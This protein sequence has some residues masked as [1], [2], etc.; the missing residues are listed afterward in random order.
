MTRT[1]AKARRC[2]QAA[3]LSKAPL[4]SCAKPCHTPRSWQ[5]FSLEPLAVAAWP[6]VPVLALP[7]GGCHHLQLAWSPRPLPWGAEL[8]VSLGDAAVQSTLPWMAAE[9]LFWWVCF[10]S[11]PPPFSGATQPQLHPQPLGQLAALHP[12]ACD[13]HGPAPQIV[14][15]LE[16]IV[17]PRPSKHPQ[18]LPH[19]AFVTLPRTYSSQAPSQALACCY[20]MAMLGFP[21]KRAPQRG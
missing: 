7:A 20:V 8:V 12:R 19:D 14:G 17:A 4:R 16:P 21:T 9:A 6:W 2:M 13:V 18:E 11:A 15:T 5:T 10:A 3:H 1:M